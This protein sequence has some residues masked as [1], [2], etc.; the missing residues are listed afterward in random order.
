MITE[1]E[2]QLGKQAMPNGQTVAE[3]LAVITN[4]D[5][6]FKDRLLGFAVSTGKGDLC[7]CLDIEPCGCF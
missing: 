5:F 3:A 1:A 6:P 2:E 4:N 7:A